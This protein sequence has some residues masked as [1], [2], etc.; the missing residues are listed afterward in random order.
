M[1]GHSSAVLVVQII[2]PYSAGNQAA[3]SCSNLTRSNPTTTCPLIKVTGVVMTPISTSGIQGLRVADASIMPLITNGN[4]NAPS[5]MIGEN[6]A[7]MR[8][9]ASA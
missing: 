2:C 5:I 8:K 4:T 3:N 7:D 6:A 9:G 1:S